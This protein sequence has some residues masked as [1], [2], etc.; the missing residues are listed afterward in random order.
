MEMYKK[1]E[2]PKIHRSL[3][4]RIFPF[5]V[6]SNMKGRLAFFLPSFFLLNLFGICHPGGFFHLLGVFICRF[7]HG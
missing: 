5:Y 6:V 7:P 2:N 1:I 4:L 3:Y